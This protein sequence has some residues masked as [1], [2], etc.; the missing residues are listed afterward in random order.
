VNIAVTLLLER[1]A[2]KPGFPSR[3]VLPLMLIPNSM[4]A[5]GKENAEIVTSMRE[6]ELTGFD[7][8]AVIDTISF[9]KS[10]IIAASSF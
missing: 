7:C 9:E 3:V 2:T 8:L 5:T 10:V 6:I 1:S 4:E